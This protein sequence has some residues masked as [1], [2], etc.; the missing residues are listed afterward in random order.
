MSSRDF[1]FGLVLLILCV[2]GFSSVR[3]EDYSDARLMP[4]FVRMDAAPEMLLVDASRA[5]L[6][7]QI[8]YE[9]EEDVP[10]NSFEPPPDKKTILWST[11]KGNKVFLYYL[12]GASLGKIESRLGTRQLPLSPQ[13]RRL[14]TSRDYPIETR[15]NAR[16]QFLMMRVEDILGMK[17][18]IP[19]LSIELYRTRKD[20][21]A[22]YASQEGINIDARS[23]YVHKHA[24]IFSSE[25]DLIDSI[26]AHEMAHAVI[27]HYF[28]APPPAQVA[29]LLAAHVD[30]HLEGP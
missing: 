21:Q 30:E 28:K 19:K 15:I 8:A 11:I 2:T 18:F 22:A 29:E 6:R 5:I 4:A 1:V 23:F 20:M 26:I 24:L 16:L 27:D 3:A 14:F 12:P 7:S 9:E 13:Y 10:E 25:Q 17:P